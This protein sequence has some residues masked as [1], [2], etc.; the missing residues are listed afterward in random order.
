MRTLVLA[1]VALLACSFGGVE[2]AAAQGCGCEAGYDICECGNWGCGRN[3]GHH[4][5]RIDGLEP[6][7]NCGCGGSYNY[8]VPPLHTY[9]WP[10]MYKQPRMIDY[11]SPWHFPPLKP[12]NEDKPLIPISGI[13]IKHSVQPASAI[14]PARDHQPTGEVR[15][16]SSRLRAA[17]R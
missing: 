16:M 17:S 10:G 3:W 1:T 9:H 7:F 11:N 8:P 15:S 12:F 6:C 4:R 2:T 13:Q 14:T 5:P